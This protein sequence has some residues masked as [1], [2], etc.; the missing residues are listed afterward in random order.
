MVRRLSRSF[1]AVML[2]LL[3]TS[4]TAL[5]ANVPFNY[6][7]NIVCCLNGRI[8]TS[9]TGDFCNWFHTTFVQK[10][11]VDR[12]V[13]VSLWDFETLTQVGQTIAY[14]TDG[15]QYLGCWW[16]NQPN[17]SY[18]FRYTKANDGWQIKGSGNVQ[19]H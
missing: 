12:W 18:Y 1:V 11:L 2:A 5:A 7:I 17:H 6:T 15:K 10:P 19:N 8:M 16:D 13:Y 9:A 3:L 4:G 14:P